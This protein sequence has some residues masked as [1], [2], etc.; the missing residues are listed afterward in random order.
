[1]FSKP[2]NI[3]VAAEARRLE[4]SLS[5]KA[6]RASTL[7]SRAAYM[8]RHHT[9]AQAA[10]SRGWFEGANR[11]YP[12][13]SPNR[14]AL[15]PH[16]TMHPQFSRGS[17][18]QDTGISDLAAMRH[19]AA[20]DHVLWK[21]LSTEYEEFTAWN[22]RPK[23]SAPAD[24]AAEAI[25]RWLTQTPRVETLPLLLCAT[26]LRNLRTD[27]VY[28]MAST[29]GV[30]TTAAANAAATAAATAATATAAVAAATG[31]LLAS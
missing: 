18:R 12:R 4:E 22:E 30:A 8:A 5:N 14:V 29:S 31:S 16:N 25:Q 10:R 19:L 9:Q 7:A 3:S 27:T 17:G 24:V 1:M 6:G 26:P 21:G 11:A 20:G 2:A 15:R 13:R 28:P 23:H